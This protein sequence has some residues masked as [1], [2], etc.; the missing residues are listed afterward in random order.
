MR[1]LRSR[2]GWL[3]SVLLFAVVASGVL[4]VWWL[5]RYTL[6]VRRLTRGV[7]DTVFYGADGQP[8]FRLDEQRHDVLLSA[9]APDLQHAVLAIEDRRFYSHPGIDPVGIARAVVRD[10]RSRGRVE[11]GST[12]TQ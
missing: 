4:S 12:I 11:G 6:A 9:I 8:W 10:V 5:S 3:A 1:W 2:S 7:G